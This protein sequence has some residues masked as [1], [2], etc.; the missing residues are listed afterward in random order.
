M[1]LRNSAQSFQKMM[2]FILEGLDSCFCYLDDIL[3]FSPNEAEHLKTLQELFRRLES[4]G[5][6][7]NLTKCKFAREELTF[8]GYTVNSSGIKPVNKKT[9][10]HSGVSAPRPSKRFARFPGGGELLP[11]VS[12]QSGW[13]NAK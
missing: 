1:G 8:L 7:I 11:P 4:N 3:I 2:N 12:A 9:N 6:T 13:K 10:S 5:L